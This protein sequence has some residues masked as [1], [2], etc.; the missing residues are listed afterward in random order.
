MNI[1]RIISA[2]C[3]N[4]E[5]VPLSKVPVEKLEELFSRVFPQYANEFKPYVLDRSDLDISVGLVSGG[6]LIGAYFLARNSVLEVIKSEN[7]TPTEDLSQYEKQSGVE[8]ICLLVDSQYRNLGYG[9]KLK[10]YPATLGVDYIFG[11]QYRDLGNLEHWS[12]RRRVVAQNEEVL[13]TLQDF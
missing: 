9:S 13:L 10:D 1:D 4:L 12:K 3:E 11:Q 2:L 8:G 6:N 7:L 5:W